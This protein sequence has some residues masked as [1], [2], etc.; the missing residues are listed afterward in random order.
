MG[1][2]GVC[3]VQLAVDAGEGGLHDEPARLE[4]DVAGA[5]GADFV[6]LVVSIQAASWGGLD[7][8]RPVVPQRKGEM[9]H[10]WLMRVAVAA[11]RASPAIG[12]MQRAQE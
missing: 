8:A 11:V 12:G 5:R 7:S 1:R 3:A 6:E 9:L 4:E 10:T 2:E